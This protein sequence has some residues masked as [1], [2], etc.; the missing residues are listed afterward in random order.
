MPSQLQM[1]LMVSGRAAY[2]MLRKL[3]YFM[4]SHSFATG[5]SSWWQPCKKALQINDKIIH[6]YENH[7]LS[8]GMTQILRSIDISTLTWPGL[9]LLLWRMTVSELRL[10]LRRR[11]LI[12]QSV[13]IRL[14]N[15]TCFQIPSQTI[16][17]DSRMSRRFSKCCGPV[18]CFWQQKK[19]E[20]KHYRKMVPGF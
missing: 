6:R 18:C 2:M 16:T 17:K 11:M 13:R 3:Q 9:N 15:P 4:S 19:G 10:S 8:L 12:L 14:P 7:S 1:A 5:T 20:K